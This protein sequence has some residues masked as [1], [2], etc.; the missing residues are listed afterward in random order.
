MR[1]GEDGC[2]VL[3]VI[4]CLQGKGERMGHNFCSTVE[5]NATVRGEKMGHCTLRIY[6]N[7]YLLLLFLQWRS[8]YSLLIV[9]AIQRG[10]CTSSMFSLLQ[11]CLFQKSRMSQCDGTS[12]ATYPSP[13][14]GLTKLVGI[15]WNSIIM[16]FLLPILLPFLLLASQKRLALLQLTQHHIL[17]LQKTA[18]LTC[19]NIAEPR[20]AQHLHTLNEPLP[21]FTSVIVGILAV[22]SAA[23]THIEWASVCFHR[24]AC[25]NPC[26]VRHS[27]WTHR[28][29]LC[30]LS[31]ACF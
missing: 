24:H 27:I 8:V 21:A 11:S 18:F 2:H 25:R 9:A 16:L 29:G 19:K 28:M 31:Q 14:W 4:R 17:L 13:F 26:S 10:W 15:V 1:Q 12:Y 3:H 23:S 20:L 30:L 6:Y 5:Q 22:Y 7:D